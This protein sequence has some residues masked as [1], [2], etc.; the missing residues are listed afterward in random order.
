MLLSSLLLLML[1]LFC[2]CPRRRRRRSCAAQ[3]RPRSC[4]RSLQSLQR[5][6]SR[7]SQR[8]PR[9][10]ENTVDCSRLA[11]VAANSGRTAPNHVG[12]QRRWERDYV[13]FS[14]HPSQRETISE[15]RRGRV[16]AS[17][18]GRQTK[19]SAPLAQASASV[20]TPP[21]ARRRDR[22]GRVSRVGCFAAVCRQR[23]GSIEMLLVD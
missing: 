12:D 10:R 8:P 14:A 9:G 15:R 5:T 7:T 13:W 20:R 22:V 11:R 17:R 23:V 6:R 2:R 3:M 16:P 4:E 21:H 1:M 19:D 18:R